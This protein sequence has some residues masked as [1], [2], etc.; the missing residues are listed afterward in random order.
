M[1]RK[2]KQFII[3]LILGSLMF[4][5]TPAFAK[6]LKIDVIFDNIKIKINGNLANI[7][8]EPF[9][10]K[11]KTY[12]PLRA[13]AEL[14]DKEVNFD[15]RNNEIN[16]SDKN[17]TISNNQIQSEIIDPAL[18]TAKRTV[19]WDGNKIITETNL[20]ENAIVSYTKHGTLKY[21]GDIYV[22]TWDLR[23]KFH[24]K[25]RSDDE[26]VYYQAKTGEVVTIS[27]EEAKN[28]EIRIVKDGG[29]AFFLNANLF[30]GLIPEEYLKE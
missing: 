20:P 8:E 14:F 17:L 15:S 2:Y 7:E 12:I 30:K 9:I 11:G 22:Y 3:G 19:I 21:N 10:Y 16:I 27:Y 1:L 24:F 25:V 4:T 6:N 29:T 13:I 28:P 26:N 23:D 5:A 18:G